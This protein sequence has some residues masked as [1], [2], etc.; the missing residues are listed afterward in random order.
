MDPTP[1]VV[2]PFTRAEA[3]GLGLTPAR[4]RL[5]VRDGAVR[6]V[7]RGVYM[8]G[9][10]PLTMEIRVAAAARVMN[11]DAVV[12][13]R[14]AA[15]IWGVD[16]F[17]F[18][19]LDGVPALETFVLRG[20]PRTS[21]AECR[22]GV[23][24]LM[25]ADWVEVG[26]VK[27]TTPLR[28]ALDLGCRLDRREALAAMDA[29]MRA[30]GFSRADLARAL[31]RYRRR[32]GVIQLRELVPLVDP[33]AESPRESWTRLEMLDFGLPSPELQWWVEVNGV[34]TYRL[35]LAYPHARIGVEYDGVENHSRPE[36]RAR[37]ES[38]RAWLG[39][40][41]WT[42][43]VIGADELGPEGDRGWLVAIQE[44]LRAAQRPPR[45]SYAR[46]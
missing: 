14:T 25:P 5:A 4:L 13:D 35:D 11:A 19:E 45:R 21:R 2:R 31:L 41:G 1:M 27:I 23:R 46:R 28:T 18:R 6:R 12:C 42:M 16:T 26:G 39:A 29:L 40:H 8:R 37:D 22:G 10:V 34:P 30:H 15:W 24:D 17:A 3:A 33:R 38:R 36:D 43:V 9:D 20:R 7:L 44:A 32:R